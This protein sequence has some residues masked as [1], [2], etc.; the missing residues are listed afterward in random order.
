M[1]TLKS[2]NI[3]DILLGDA[4]SN[5]LIGEDTNDLLFGDLGSDTLTGDAGADIFGYADDP[6]KG[7]DVSDPE[8]QIIAEE[9]FITDFDFAEDRYLINARDFKI[10][11]NVD[12]ASVDSN[13]A[14]ASIEPGTNVVTLLNSDNDDNQDTPFIAGTAAEEIAE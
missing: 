9:D 3:E 13:D 5:K 2:F 14:D 8:R 11:G 4:D 7:E 1:D 12:F 6:F 10:D